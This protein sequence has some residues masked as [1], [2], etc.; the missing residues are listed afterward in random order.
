MPTMGRGIEERNV[1]IKWRRSRE[2]SIHDAGVC[3]INVHLDSRDKR[4]VVDEQSEYRSR[5]TI[6]TE[7][8]FVKN[9]AL[10]LMGDI[11]NPDT[12]DLETR[13]FGTGVKVL[14]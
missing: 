12:S 5:L 11:S 3:E 14:P 1:L 9:P 10:A 7:K 6:I 4:E 13:F 8:C 2:W